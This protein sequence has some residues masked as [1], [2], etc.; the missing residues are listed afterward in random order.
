MLTPSMLLP[1]KI[2]L[3]IELVNRLIDLLT[4]VKAFLQ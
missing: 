1:A 4:L 3:M 2:H